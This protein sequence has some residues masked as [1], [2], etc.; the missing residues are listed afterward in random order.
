[1]LH[2]LIRLPIYLQPLCQYIFIN[3]EDITHFKLLK[4]LHSK[5]VERPIGDGGEGEGMKRG[6]GGRKS[7]G[8]EEGEVRK[9]GGEEEGRGGRGEGRKRGGEEE[10]RGGR[11]DGEGRG[12]GEVSFCISLHKCFIE[13]K[14]TSLVSTSIIQ[15]LIILF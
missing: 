6:G 8:G 10:G 14:S 11:G 4:N 2:L 3:V 9:R 13:P 7:G 5:I 1:M 12:R 15:I